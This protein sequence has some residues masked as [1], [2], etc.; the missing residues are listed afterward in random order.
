MQSK[1]YLVR[2]EHIPVRAACPVI[3]AHNHLWGQ[4]DNVDEYV[5]VMD[6]V[7]VAQYADLTSNLNLKFVSGGYEFA[8][9]DIETFFEKCA[10]RHPGRFFGFTAAT[11]SRPKN[12]P[13]F[14]DAGAFV[15]ETVDLLERHVARGARGLKILKELGLHYRDGAG[16]LI[17][18]DDP[19]LAPIW[20]AAG[21]L[22][23]PVMLHQADPLGFFD[24]VTPDN[25]HYDSLLK[26]PSW[27]FA[28]PR[29]FPR[30]RTILAQR[31]HLLARHP[32]TTFILAHAAGLSEDLCEVSRILDTYPNACIDFSA[33]L[34]ELGRQPY[35]SRE[36]ML[37]YRDRILFGT[38]MP[39]TLEMYRCYFRFLETFDEYF[40]P[41]DY[42]GTFSRA[43]WAIYGIGLPSA[44]LEDIYY[45]NAL[46]LIPGLE[47]H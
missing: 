38:D 29:Q 27:S 15:E 7:G 5:R 26:Y 31:D 16:Q 9:A 44:V 36:F 8:P 2:K 22:G 1:C 47:I 34:D 33:R 11:F 28:D 23:I 42:D 19:R 43:R 45:K 3:D 25:E 39:P 41:P 40:F 14:T 46:R 21:A 18:V 35:T 24:P 10:D 32:R 13:L 30:P 20:E 4:W 37:R 17:A 6:E 12:Q